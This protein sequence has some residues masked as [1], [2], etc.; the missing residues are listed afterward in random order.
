VALNHVR[1]I[2]LIDAIDAKVREVFVSDVWRVT[3]DGRDPLRGGASD[4]RW[5]NGAFSVLYTSLER[6]G[7]AAEVY[8]FLAEQ[9]VFPSKL[10]FNAHRLSVQ[11]DKILRFADVSS[12]AALGVDVARYSSRDYVQTQAIADAA[13]FLEFDGLIAPSARWNCMNAMLFNERISGHSIS[14]ECLQTEPVDWA[15]L[16]L[17][18][19]KQ[20]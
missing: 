12:F 17:S 4:S 16:R 2:A 3:R 11:A 6:N 10:R 14:L 20:T 15:Q 9:P 18:M 7:A 1:D 8:S 5:C 19:R 13:Y